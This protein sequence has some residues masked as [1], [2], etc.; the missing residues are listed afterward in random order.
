MRFLTLHL[1]LENSRKLTGKE[2][3][4]CICDFIQPFYIGFVYFILSRTVKDLMLKNS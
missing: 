3:I 4:I 1:E 2:I